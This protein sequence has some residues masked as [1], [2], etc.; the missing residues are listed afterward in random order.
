MSVQR[1]SALAALALMS[2]LTSCQNAARPVAV[3]PTIQQMDALDVQ[4]GLP[5]R[6]QRGSTGPRRFGSP[7]AGSATSSAPAATAPVA[8]PAAAPTQNAVD[9]A[10]IQSLQKQ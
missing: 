9:P 1:L 7:D 4:W 5:K 10:V 6:Q 3:N 2:S 8:A